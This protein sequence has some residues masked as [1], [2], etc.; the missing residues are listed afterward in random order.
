MVVLAFDP[1]DCCQPK[2]TLTDRVQPTR[3]DIYANLQMYPAMD[4]KIDNDLY[5]LFDQVI[6]RRRRLQALT[7]RQRTI[8]KPKNCFAFNSLPALPKPKPV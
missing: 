4:V 2:L 7:A 1:M 6:Q 8:L 3:D 5:L